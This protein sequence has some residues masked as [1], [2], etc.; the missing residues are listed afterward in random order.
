MK[1]TISLWLGLLAFAFT[2]AFAQTTPSEPTTPSAPVIKGP[3]GSIHGHITG[4]EGNPKTTGTVCLST[5]SGHTYK[6]TFEVS[7]TGDYH[8]VA[9]PGTYTALYRAPES[10]PGMMVDY[11]DNV[12]IVA[13]QDVLQDFDMTR[14]AFS[15][16]LDWFRQ[17]GYIG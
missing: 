3:T 9:S 13:G 1:R 12:K 14:K 5:D 6:F 15:D 10:K 11:F 4:P 16:A 8:G 2:T 17:E 7:S